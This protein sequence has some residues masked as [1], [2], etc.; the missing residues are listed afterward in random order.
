LNLAREL[1]DDLGQALTAVK[2]DM[3]IIKQ[4]SSETAV[5][6]K[7]EDVKILVGT[8]IRTVQRIT[9]ELRPEI[10]DDLGL[11]AAIDWYTKEYAKRYGVEI[12]LDIENEIPI[13]NDDALPLFR[14]LQESLTNIARHAKATHIEILLNQQNDS[15]KFEMRDNGVG[16]TEDQIKSKK[17]FGIMSMKERAESL[18]GNFEINHG[19]KFGTSI[20]ISFPINKS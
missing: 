1:H 14:I 17:S 2:I 15:I 7:L 16:I 13:S 9:S 18:G 4:K 3:E 12:F 6:E 8:T 20:T 5:K 10:I 19:E 11:E